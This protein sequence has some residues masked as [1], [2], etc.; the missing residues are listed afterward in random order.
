MNCVVR[1][2][3]RYQPDPKKLHRAWSGRDIRSY[4]DNV[5]WTQNKNFKCKELFFV[6]LMVVYF[7]TNYRIDK[8]L[9]IQLLTFRIKKTAQQVL[10]INL[11][12]NKLFCLRSTVSIG[13]CSWTWTESRLALVSNLFRLWKFKGKINKCVCRNLEKGN[14]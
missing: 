13:R 12:H 6:I 3:S 4:P 8:Y 2:M 10:Q 1:H 5:R 7:K 11:P 14:K 9:R